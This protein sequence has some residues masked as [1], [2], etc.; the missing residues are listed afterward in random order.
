MEM[1]ETWSHAHGV[2][3][4]HREGPPNKTAQY[5]LPKSEWKNVALTREHPGHRYSADPGERNE[6]RI[7]PMKRGKDRTGYQGRAHGTFCCGEKAIG[8]VG[9]QPH[10]LEKA[11]GHIAKEM[12]GNQVMVERPVRTTKNEPHEAK[13]DSKRSEQHCRAFGGIPQIIRPPSKR[14][15]SV[16][17]QHKAGDQP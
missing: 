14:S 16:P 9:I 2:M 6:Y 7:R 1:I 11:K 13:S 5:G 3:P 10:L 8:C 12:L 15:W 17:V 4:R